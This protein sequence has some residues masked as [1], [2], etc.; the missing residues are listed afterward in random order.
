MKFRKV[1]GITKKELEGG[2]ARGTL[3]YSVEFKLIR[4]YVHYSVFRLLIAYFTRF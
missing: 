1:D 3:D 2:S 4:Y